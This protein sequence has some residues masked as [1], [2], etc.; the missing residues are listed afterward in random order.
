MAGGMAGIFNW[1]GA[2]PIDTL[3]SK[4]QVAP[5]GMY[6]NGMRSVAR[7]NPTPRLSSPP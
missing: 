3:K 7:G 6:P 5:E 4:L 2:L 1:L